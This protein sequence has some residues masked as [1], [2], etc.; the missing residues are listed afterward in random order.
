MI[1]KNKKAQTLTMSTQITNFLV[2]LKLFKNINIKTF[3]ICLILFVSLQSSSAI[4]D[5]VPLNKLISLSEILVKGKVIKKSSKS[6]LMIRRINQTSDKLDIKTIE[7]NTPYTTYVISID[8]VLNGH[9]IK[10]TIEVK[11]EGGCGDDGLCLTDSANYDYDVEDKVVIFLSY[12]VDNKHYYSTE[13]GLTAFKVN[14][15][16]ML[17]RGEMIIIS[18]EYSIKGTREIKNNP[19]S[20]DTLREEIRVMKND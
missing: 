16:K 10:D 8:E 2:F 20:L 13:A 14:N 15:E 3:P 18:K 17:Y 6:E 19:I 12:D 11:M 7:T 5:D 4:F 1:T 9:Y